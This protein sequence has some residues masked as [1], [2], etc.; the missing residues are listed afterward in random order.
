MFLSLVFYRRWYFI[1]LESHPETQKVRC[2][3]QY[4]PRCRLLYTENTHTHEKKKRETRIFLFF[5]RSFFL[6]CF[7]C[8]RPKNKHGGYFSKKQKKTPPPWE[9]CP[10]LLE[11]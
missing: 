7:F 8:A 2:V 1:T 10:I 4:L 9:G 6:L 3:A 5:V 11:D